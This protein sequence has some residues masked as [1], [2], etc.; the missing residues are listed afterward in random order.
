MPDLY[1]KREVCIFS[2]YWGKLV[3]TLDIF[4]QKN[5]PVTFKE[6]SSDEQEHFYG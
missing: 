3:Q 6:T 1:K 2:I 5:V 4:I